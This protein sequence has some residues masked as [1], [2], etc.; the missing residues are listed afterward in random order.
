MHGGWQLFINNSGLLFKSRYTRHK[1]SF[2]KSKYGLK[3][4]LLKYIWE[5]K[6][7]NKD[8]ALCGKFLHELKQI[9]FKT[10][11]FSLHYGKTRDLKIKPESS[12]K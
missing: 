5:L 10:L 1:C 12:F 6:D 2:N 4:T 8:L 7:R 3:T 9:Q 11:L